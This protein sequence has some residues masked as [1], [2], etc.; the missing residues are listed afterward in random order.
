MINNVQYSIIST[1]DAY[2]PGFHCTAVKVM[3]IEERTVKAIIVPRI[4][5]EKEE[6]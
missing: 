5:V 3:D 6:K 4:V 1:E 2:F